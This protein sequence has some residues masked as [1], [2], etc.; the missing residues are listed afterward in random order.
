MLRKNHGVGPQLSSASEIPEVHACASSA[1][2]LSLA[3]SI[4]PLLGA[5]V[6]SKRPKAWQTI[7]VGGKLIVSS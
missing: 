5:G 7:E 6:F 1:S 3:E 2:N 4:A